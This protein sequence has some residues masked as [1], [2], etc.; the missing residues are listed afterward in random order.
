MDYAQSSEPRPLPV[1][2]TAVRS[3]KIVIAGSFGVGKTTFVGAVSE[4]APLRTEEP[5]TT[6]S[7]GLDDLSGT[8][9]KTTTTVGT[10]FGRIHLSPDLVLYIFGTPGQDRFRTLWRTVLDGAL[11]VL[12][13]VDVRT[14]EQ[15]HSV[16]D[17]LEREGARY[18]VAV[19]LFDGA[20]RYP[21][22]EIRQALALPDDVLLTAVDARD[23][24]SGITALVDLLAHLAPRELLRSPSS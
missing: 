6:A 17:L 2:T 9:D 19:N 12:V 16:L 5:I 15:S 4:V 20:P 14:L 18:A 8:P 7:T 11:G 24:H 22:A 10:D 23:R 13:L 3:A 21:G 1:P